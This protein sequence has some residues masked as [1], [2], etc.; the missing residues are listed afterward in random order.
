MPTQ[1]P[2]VDQIATKIDPRSTLAITVSAE[3]LPTVAMKRR[4]ASGF[5]SLYRSEKEWAA[6]LSNA[7]SACC[8]APCMGRAM[9]RPLS[10]TYGNLRQAPAAG[11]DLPEDHP[12][13]P[14][15]HR[16]SG[17]HSPD[18]ALSMSVTRRQSCHIAPECDGEDHR[19][20]SLT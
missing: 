4:A 12:T 18:Q 1:T 7:T 11:W 14:P 20:R 9:R 8:P 3:S 15:L 17:T 2:D 19:A 13:V 16:L 5:V 10:G 6:E